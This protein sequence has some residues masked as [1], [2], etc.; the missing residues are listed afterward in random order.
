M[1]VNYKELLQSLCDKMQLDVNNMRRSNRPYIKVQLNTGIIESQILMYPTAYAKIDVDEETIYLQREEFEKSVPRDTAEQK[2][3][4]RLLD[5]VFMF[6]VMGSR[7]YLH[8]L[9]GKTE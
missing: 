6:G 7:E 2:I 4:K 9:R 5:Q 1:E 8:K 3:C